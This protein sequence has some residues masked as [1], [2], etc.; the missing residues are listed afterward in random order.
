MTALRVDA[1]TE[2]QLRFLAQCVRNEL[3]AAGLPVLNGGTDSTLVGGAEVDVDLA[4]DALGGVYVTW[5]ATPRLRDCARHALAQQQLDAPVIGYSHA[6]GVA[7]AKAIAAVLAAAGY[8][9][10]DS[11]DEYNPD[12]V[13]VRRGLAKGELPM[14]ALRD[15]ELRPPAWT[16]PHPDR[17]GCSTTDPA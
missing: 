15:E 1:E 8:T 11:R 6:I 7:M 17:C 2:A 16:N 5:K 14:W 3:T 4:N 13:F 10:E 9:V 12:A